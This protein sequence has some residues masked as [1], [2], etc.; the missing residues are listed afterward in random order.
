MGDAR[1]RVP[2]VAMR[3]VWVAI[4]PRPATYLHRGNTYEEEVGYLAGIIT[5]RHIGITPLH[6]HGG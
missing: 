3:H 2:S 1:T 4:P 6:Y 5:H